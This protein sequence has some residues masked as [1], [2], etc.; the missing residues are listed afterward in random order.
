MSTLSEKV[1]ISW[2]N[3][4]HY[5]NRRFITEDFMENNGIPRMSL[6]LCG[7]LPVTGDS[8]K[9]NKHISPD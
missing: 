4:I 8:L 1:D 6:T 2:S 9:S 5:N 7:W 3:I